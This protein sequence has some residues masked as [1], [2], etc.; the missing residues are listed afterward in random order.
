MASASECGPPRAAAS[1]QP[2]EPRGASASASATNSPRPDA[3]R[4]F[5]PSRRIRNRA[6]FQAVYH[7]GGR[8]GAELFTVFVLATGASRPAR[9]GLTVTRKIGNATVRNRCKRLLREAVRRNWSA[10]PDGFD[11][12]L[13]ARRG[14]ATA[15]ARDVENEVARLLPEAVRRTA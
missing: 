9:V 10:L 12:V 11:V 14:L 2:V 7:G 8:L 6:G 15:R 4:G 3:D 13:H 1:S 5:P